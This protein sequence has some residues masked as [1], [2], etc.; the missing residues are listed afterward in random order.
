MNITRVLAHLLIFVLRY[1][2]LF[3][4]LCVLFCV[5]L[6]VFPPEVVFRSRVVGACPVSTDCI[7]ANGLM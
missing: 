3:H 6:F 1:T 7:V 5:F 4:L 2:K